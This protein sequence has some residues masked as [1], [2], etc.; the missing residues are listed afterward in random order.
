VRSLRSRPWAL[1]SN[2][3]GVAI[4]KN[5]AKNP[6]RRCL[7]GRPRDNFINYFLLDP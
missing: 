7:L 3:F 2:A 4:A 5:H 6:S 1:R